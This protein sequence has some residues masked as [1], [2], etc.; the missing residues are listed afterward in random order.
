MVHELY[1]AGLDLHTVLG[2]L[3]RHRRLAE[4][5]VQ[6][7][8]TRLDDTIS[9][10]HQTGARLALAR[11]APTIDALI[12]LPGGIDLAHYLHTLTRHCAGLLDVD[13]AAIVLTGQDV[14]AAGQD[15]A[16]ARELCQLHEGPSHDTCNTG[17]PVTVADLAATSRWPLFT[18]R[19]RTAG[20]QAVH[21]LPLSFAGT[22]L[23]ALALFSVS[24]HEPSAGEVQLAEGVADFAAFAIT[25]DG[26]LRQRDSL[27]EQIRTTLVD[28]AVVDQAKGVL[29]ER[30]GLPVDAAQSVMNTHS[31]LHDVHLIDTAQAIVDGTA[32]LSDTVRRLR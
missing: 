26:V 13:A 6:A 8:I 1:A 28:H 24:A 31:D 18:T 23:G 12:A 29:A 3:H 2:L 22:P 14:A 16:T 25:C 7:V 27:A 32:D 11:A 5:R 15:A 9:T 10:I 30:H 17:Q 19:A 20:F 4:D 21:T